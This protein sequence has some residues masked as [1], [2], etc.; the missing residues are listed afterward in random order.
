MREAS[1]FL[2]DAAAMLHDG[3]K[4]RSDGDIATNM[5]TVSPGHFEGT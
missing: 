1:R 2:E 3:I 5:L 4:S